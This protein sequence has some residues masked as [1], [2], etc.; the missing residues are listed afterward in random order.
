MRRSGG[1]E[2]GEVGFRLLQASGVV[3]EN[4]IRREPKFADCLL[5]PSRLLIANTCD[6][7]IRMLRGHAQQIAYVEVIKIDSD[8][9][10]MLGHEGLEFAGG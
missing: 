9:T 8:D 2:D 1:A 5:H 3:R 7:R 10:K 4:A 6:F